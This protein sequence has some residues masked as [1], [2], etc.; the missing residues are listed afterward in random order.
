MRYQQDLQVKL[1]DRLRKLMTA[2]YSVAAH[3]IRLAV[4]WINGQP[5][6]KSILSEAEGVEP[7]LEVKS[8]LDSIPQMQGQ[9]SW[10]SGTEAGRAVLVRNLMLVIAEADKTG[11]GSNTLFQYAHGATWERNMNDGWRGMA[12][13]VLAPLFDYL[14]EH[15]GDESSV[16]HVLERYV[17]RVE[18]FDREEL[19]E[20]FKDNT[21]NGEEVYN[22]DLQRFLFL[23]GNYITH[24]KPRSAT[25][26]AD[27]IGELD[28]DDPLV[29]DGKIFD[30]GS[31]GKAYLAKGVNQVVQ[32]AHDHQ[33][34]VAYLVIFNM[35]GQP[36]E[37]PTDG[38]SADWPRYLDLSGVR[39]YFVAVRA[40]PP[41]ATASKLGKA[42]PYAITREQLI[43][44]D[45][46]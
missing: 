43:N 15:V 35:S 4:E 8:W 19:H 46:E 32:Y 30:G 16:L 1:R 41:Q 39:V 12:E 44:P 7:D 45:A 29:C 42:S 21:R 17:R 22:L 11:E 27:L 26:E 14:G 25:G 33:K 37:M 9:L 36:L 10:T 18:W 24:A 5:M 13:Q 3:E 40:L 34:T 20:R 23:E 2:R 38:R 6:L 28:T 31:R